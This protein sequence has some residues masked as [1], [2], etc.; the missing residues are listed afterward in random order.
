[1][2]AYMKAAALAAV[3]CIFVSIFM[4]ALYQHPDLTDKV[5]ARLTRVFQACFSGVATLIMV[6]LAFYVLF[7]TD[8]M[9]NAIMNRVRSSSLLTAEKN[10]AARSAAS[11]L[12]GDLR[13]RT[14]GLPGFP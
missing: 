14:G 3:A 12:A 9:Q 5:D 13:P 8:E 1:M 11:S 10:L 4:D 6:G 2:N 7:G